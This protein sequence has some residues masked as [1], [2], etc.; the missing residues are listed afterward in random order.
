MAV[1]GSLRRHTTHPAPLSA[2][3]SA[4]A[5]DITVSFRDRPSD[6]PP[7]PGAVVALHGA[8]DISTAPQLREHL[9]PLL[10]CHVTIDLQHCSFI[11]GSIIGLLV[12]AQS[13]LRRRGGELLV[14]SAA[15]IP[16]LAL[17]TLAQTHCLTVYDAAGE[18]LTPVVARPA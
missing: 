5:P 16:A 13:R 1:T 9:W 10:S 12:G 2:A 6:D 17:A 11:D 18:L 4:A 8:H 3:S 15:G 14:T 7:H